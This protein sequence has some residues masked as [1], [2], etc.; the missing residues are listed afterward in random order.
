MDIGY[1]AFVPDLLAVVVFNVFKM[2][3]VKIPE[4]WAI[5]LTNTVPTPRNIIHVYIKPS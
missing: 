3:T 2:E 5:W 1:I 4:T